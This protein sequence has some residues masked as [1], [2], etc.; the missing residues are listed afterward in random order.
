MDNPNSRTE[1]MT[2]R[3]EG[4]MEKV[5]N[6]I[7]SLDERFELEVKCLYNVRGADD[8]HQTPQAHNTDHDC[9]G[10]EAQQ[11]HDGNFGSSTHLQTLEEEDG[12]NGI[13]ERRRNVQRR[14]RKA[15]ACQLC[16]CETPARAIT[17]DGLERDAL[18]HIDEKAAESVDAHEYH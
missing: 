4:K 7:S 6:T 11:E 16:D 13:E 10:T 3:L 9:S 18:Q 15:E 8:Q 1:L 14:Y 12:Q 17:P 2:T 5:W